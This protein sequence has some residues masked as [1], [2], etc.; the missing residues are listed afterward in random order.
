MKATILAVALSGVAFAAPG[1]YAA[2]KGEGFKDLTN[3]KYSNELPVA[4]AAASVER[5]DSATLASHEADK[6]VKD[7]RKLHYNQNN[8]M[9]IAESD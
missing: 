9:P 7:N 8:K 6:P 3:L 4:D 2:D 5:R 1:I